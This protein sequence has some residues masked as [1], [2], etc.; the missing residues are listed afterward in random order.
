GRIFDL[1]T[2]RHGI[3]AS[4]LIFDP[5]T[6]T[7]CTGN[8]DDRKLGEETLNALAQIK[9]EC[10]G[11]HTLLGLSNTLLQLTCALS[12]MA[13]DLILLGRSDIGELH[14]GASGGSS[15][16][17]QKLNPVASEALRALAAYAGVLQGGMPIASCHAEQRDGVS[18][19]LEW[20]LIPQ[21]VVA[22]GAA[23]SHGCN[24]AISLKPDRE[25]IAAQLANDTIMAEAASFALAAHMPRDEAQSL[26]KSA[27]TESR[28]SGISLAQVLPAMADDLVTD[29]INWAVVL[30]PAGVITPADQI[31]AQIF[32]KRSGP[33]A[34]ITA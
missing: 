32:D 8:E 9:E 31:T 22:S 23:L 34:D 15:T 26:V 24:L 7:I 6:F 2:K 30:D 13:G 17:P 27:V 3:K 21:V 14:S 12:K 29:Q 5:L 10:P 19:P 20:F 4:D 18:W 1:V 16:M 33:Q 28:R 25:R 11:V